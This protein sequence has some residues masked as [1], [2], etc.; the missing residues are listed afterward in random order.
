MTKLNL[1]TFEIIT[2]ITTTYQEDIERWLLKEDDEILQIEFADM[3]MSL[4]VAYMENGTN[5]S[6]L[7]LIQNKYISMEETKCLK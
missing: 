7:S 4:Y 2:A 6:L 5:Q 1:E 3:V